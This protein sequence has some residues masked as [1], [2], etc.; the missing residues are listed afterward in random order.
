MFLDGAGELKRLLRPGLDDAAAAFLV[1]AEAVHKQA[2]LRFSHA[3]LEKLKSLLEPGRD[4]AAAQFLEDAKASGFVLPAS[5]K[6]TE[7]KCPISISTM[8]NA[9]DGI[10]ENVGRLAVITSNRYADL[11]P[12]ITRAGRIDVEQ[13]MGPAS[14]EVLS[15][16]VAAHYGQGLSKACKREFRDIQLKGCDITAMFKTARSHKAFVDK[17][18]KLVN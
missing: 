11:D 4:D 14:V 13:Y 10:R 1:Q 3:E 18:R 2:P 7:R 5:M 8:L 17:L 12:A 15:D 16:M 9:L 6:N